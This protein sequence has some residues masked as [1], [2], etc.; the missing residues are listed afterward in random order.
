MSWWPHHPV[1]GVRV[2]GC[3]HVMNKG[4]ACDLSQPNGSQ[5]WNFSHTDWESGSPL[6]AI[7]AAAW[8]WSAEKEAHTEGNS[9]GKERKSDAMIKSLIWLY[10]S[11]I[12]ISNLPIISSLHQNRMASPSQSFP[13][14]VAGHTSCAKSEL[15]LCDAL[16]PPA[17]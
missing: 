7:L 13:A 14:R 2:C 10:Q 9:R 1:A 15:Y 17:L 8:T 3:V 11:Q 16:G 6:F 12:Y 5:L 4:G